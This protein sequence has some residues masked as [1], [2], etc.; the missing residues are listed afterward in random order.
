MHAMTFLVWVCT[1]ASFAW[2]VSCFFRRRAVTARRTTLVARLGML[3]AIWD[4]IA[5]L[6]SEGT[7][8]DDAIGIAAFIMALLLFWSVVRACGHHRP[9]AIFEHQAPRTLLCRGPYR[10]IR[11]PFYTSYTIFWFAGAIAGDSILAWLMACI[12]LALYRDAI[13][14]EE[15]EIER[16]PLAEAYGAYRRRAGAMLPKIQRR[17]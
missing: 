9:H 14:R 17:R 16:S 2:G 4:A 15:R 1:G 6:T 5:I 10:Y 11:H 12:M 8:V 7:L 13:R 3:F